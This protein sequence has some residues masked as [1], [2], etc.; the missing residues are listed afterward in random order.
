VHRFLQKTSKTIE[1][2]L[3]LVQESWLS[4]PAKKNVAIFITKMVK[5]DERYEI[6]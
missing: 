4:K 2:M 3:K 5:V 6:E 1:Q